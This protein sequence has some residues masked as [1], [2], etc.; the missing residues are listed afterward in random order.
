[1]TTTDFRLPNN[2]PYSKPQH[3]RPSSK[4]RISGQIIGRTKHKYHS[5]L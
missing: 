5:L 3:Q 2:N 4:H 1:M